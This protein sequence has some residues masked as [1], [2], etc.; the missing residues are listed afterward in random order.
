MECELHNVM[1]I[2]FQYVKYEIHWNFNAKIRKR[3]NK[4]IYSSIY[5]M[6]SRS[7]QASVITVVRHSNL[8]TI[9]AWKNKTYSF[10]IY[11]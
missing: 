4:D 5:I 1:S 9:G 2:F 8:F 6:N 7:L 3:G 11:Y 10:M